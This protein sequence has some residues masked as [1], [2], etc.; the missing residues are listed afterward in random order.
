[1]KISHLLSRS[2]FLVLFLLCCVLA[3]AQETSITVRARAK[4][5]KFI[6][7]SM[8]GARILIKNAE[9][10]KILAEGVTEGDTGNT[11]KIMKQAHERYQGLSDNN[12]AGFTAILEL[13]KPVFVTVEAH[14]P[15]NSKQAA[16]TS[17]TQLWLFPGKDITGDGLVLELPGFA[18]NILSHQTHETVVAEKHVEIKANIVMMCGCPVT[19]E[20]LWDANQ[21]EI[22]AIISRGPNQLQEISLES[23]EKPSTF[24]ATTR[25]DPG[26]YDIMVYAFDPVSGNSGLDTTNVIVK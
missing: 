14:G 7:S 20:G 6:G 17:S 13:K 1:M 23:A 12:T 19:E 5:A 9:T 11:E 21:Y 26:N 2:C 15:L 22:K 4:D 18:V 10:G 25:L 3:Q 8:G 16:V 24:T